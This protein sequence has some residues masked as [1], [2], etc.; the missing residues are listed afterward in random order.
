MLAKPN[1]PPNEAKS[2]RP[3]S[4]LP[5][6]SKVYEKILLK[7]IKPILDESNLIPNHQFGF[8]ESHGTIERVH[9]VACHAWKTKNIVQQ[10]SLMSHKHS[11]WHVGLL[12]KIKAKLPHPL[13]EVLKLYLSERH[14]FVKF[15]EE[16][17]TLM[18]IAAGVPQGSVLG[19]TLYLIYT[20][21]I[22]E[23]PQTELSTFAE[24]TA[25]MSSNKDMNVASLHLQQNLVSFEK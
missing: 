14:F 1:K 20:A 11:I 17:S 8:R 15:N 25:I 18:P 5:I 23:L 19:P 3:T 22:P 6:L 2:Y 4:L 13:Y 21:D 16:R 7:R 12:C 10:Y 9:R 24:D